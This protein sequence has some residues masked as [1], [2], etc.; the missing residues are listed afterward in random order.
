MP[1]IGCRRVSDLYKMTYRS[2]INDVVEY[3]PRKTK[4]DRPITVRVPLND[5]ALKLIAKYQKYSHD[6]F[7]SVQH[8]QNYNR[9][10]KEVQPNAGLDRIVTV[11]DQQTRQ[12]AKTPLRSG[13]VT[14]RRD[15]R[16]SATSQKVNK[17]RIWSEH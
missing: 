17:D 4:E 5:T 16:L 13:I 9:K 14:Q 10:I 8:E 6:S 3:I 7:I 15:V 1:Y 12:E 11:L 2:I